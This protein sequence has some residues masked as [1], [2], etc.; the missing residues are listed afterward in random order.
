MWIYFVPE[1]IDYHFFPT[2]IFLCSEECCIGLKGSTFWSSFTY[3]LLQQKIDELVRK[4]WEKVNKNKYWFWSLGRKQRGCR[5]YLIDSL[6]CFAV[7][8]NRSTDVSY[9]KLF[10]AVTV[11]MK[12]LRMPTFLL[13]QVSAPFSWSLHLVPVLSISF[14]LEPVSVCQKISAWAL[15][16]CRCSTSARP[17]LETDLRV[18]GSVHFS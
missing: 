2:C 12:C 15:L 1:S 3:Y 5:H 6:T 11:T 14:V 10:P 18:N 17:C 13:S 8:E 7:E 4:E 16:K 9:M